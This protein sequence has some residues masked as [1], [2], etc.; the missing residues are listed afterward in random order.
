M[1]NLTVLVSVRNGERTMKECVDSLLALDY[2]P[3]FQIIIVDNLSI[4]STT[5]ILD[6]YGDKITWKTLSGTVPAVYNKVIKDLDTEFV[7]LT[8]A[9]CVVDKNWITDLVN[10]FT[11][12]DVLVTA[13]YCATYPPIN[14]LQKI[15]GEELET[16]FK[17]FPRYLDRAPTMNMCIRTEV[18]K[19]MKFD[20]TLFIGYDTD[21]GYRVKKKGDMKYVPSAIIQHNHRA[22][23]KNYFRQQK[24]YG[25]FVPLIY[26]KHMNKATGDHISTG[27]MMMQPFITL[28]ALFFLG[29][30]IFYKIMIAPFLFF[31]AVLLAIYY[32]DYKKIETEELF[33]VFFVMFGVRTIA[34]MT[35]LMLGMPIAI[36]HMLK[37]WKVIS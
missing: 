7:A 18:A 36:K 19:E 23:W 20:E 15:I 25:K 17:S 32:H 14:K 34:W 9:D 3:G 26:I 12:P 21:F 11:S 1:A 27:T 22:S 8:D 28:L 30:F 35:G 29:G 31:L 33:P 24:T 16:R 37:E 5:K 6:S 4:D 13:G 10:G 2:K